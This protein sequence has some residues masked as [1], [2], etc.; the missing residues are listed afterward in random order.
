M[1]TRDYLA[2]TASLLIVGIEAQANSQPVTDTQVCKATI[3][4]VMGRDPSIIKLQKQQN[5][6]IYVSYIRK[7]DS[8][9]WTYRC[10]LKGNKVIWASEKG[11]WR[12]HSL[13]SK[14]VYSIHDNTLKI[15][16][17]HTDGSTTKKSF[18]I[19]KL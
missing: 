9:K 6:V 11:R 17:Q 7:S 3:A 10:K 1:K 16:E 18:K 14:I 4:T 15:S 12:E 2:L 13:D 8:S 5:S 19:S